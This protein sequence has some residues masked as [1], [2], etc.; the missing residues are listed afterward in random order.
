[1]LN[2]D[3]RR[4]PKRRAYNRIVQGYSKVLTGLVRVS[5]L[6][7]ED[8]EWVVKKLNGLEEIMNKKITNLVKKIEAQDITIKQPGD[9]L[10][11]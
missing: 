2:S 6:S 3:K 1:M 10:P 5:F 4:S 8:Q 11:F 7:Q 9:D